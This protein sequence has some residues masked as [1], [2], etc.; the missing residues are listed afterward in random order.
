MYNYACYSY[1]TG[2]YKAGTLQCEEMHVLE[3]RNKKS[4]QVNETFCR[5]GAGI[6]EKQRKQLTTTDILECAHVI[7]W[8]AG[9]KPTSLYL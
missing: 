4:T 3:V 1:G 6:I 8:N 7:M 5:Y 9:P 2:S